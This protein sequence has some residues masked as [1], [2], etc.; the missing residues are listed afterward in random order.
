MGFGERYVLRWCFTRISGKRDVSSGYS[1]DY[2]CLESTA[3]KGGYIYCFIL[4]M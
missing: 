4:N 1:S 2:C 3:C